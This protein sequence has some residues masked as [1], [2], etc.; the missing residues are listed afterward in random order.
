MAERIVSP[1]VFTRENDQSFI[2]Q[3][4]ASIGASIIGPTVK[5]PAFAPTVVTSFSEF[6]AKFGGQSSYTYVP[7]SVRDYLQNAGSM[8]VMRVLAGGGYSF[9]G[10]TKK[11]VAAVSAS[12]IMAVFHP[13]KNADDS[14]IELSKTLSSSLGTS[15]I[16][17]SNAFGIDFSGSA[18]ESAFTVTASINP[19]RTDYITR[20]IGTSPDNSG[21]TTDKAY[22]YLN[23][24][25]EQT[26]A[27]SN[28]PTASV[29]LVLSDAACT[30]SSS[31]TEGYD[32]ASTPWIT[33]QLLDSGGT[34]SNLFKFHHLADG[35]PTN[36]IVTGKRRAKRTCSVRKY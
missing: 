35:N 33:S 32:H 36:Q 22:V 19:T 15:P 29:N 12:T 27:V 11:L 20:A 7:F 34:T 14:T 2:A 5:G 6:E 18:F 30:F 3:G 23:F 9:D 10:S 4:V 28:T 8:L 25:N 16:S 1:G 13:S 21:G 31:F 24:K 26:T 17:M